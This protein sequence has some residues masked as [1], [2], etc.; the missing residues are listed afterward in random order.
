[1]SVFW[2]LQNDVTIIPDHHAYKVQ[3]IR[4]DYEAAVE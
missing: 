3:G 4:E 2:T 1:V